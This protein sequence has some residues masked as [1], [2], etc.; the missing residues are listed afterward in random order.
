MKVKV[1]QSCWTPCN[2]I[3]QSLEFSRSEYWSVQPFPSPGSLPNPGIKPRS[4]TLQSG[5]L[6]AEP[7]GKPKN[8]G[9]GSLLLLQG[10]FPTQ[11]SNQG[12]LH[13]RWILY[14]LSHQRSPKCAFFPP[15]SAQTE[16]DLPMFPSGSGL[17]KILVSHAWVNGMGLAPL[18]YGVGV[19]HPVPR[20]LC[21]S[22]LN[23]TGCPSPYTSLCTV[24]FGSLLDFLFLKIS[25]LFLFPFTFKKIFL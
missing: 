17:L 16:T 25:L 8:T 3:D 9:V 21:S 19:Q 14:Q 1:A 22:S 20:R 2:S 6:P 5:S 11:E 7:P 24:I 23:M 12:L 13:C 10:I 15:L 18:T 4:P